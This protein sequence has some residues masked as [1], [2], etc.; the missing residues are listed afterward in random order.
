MTHR[1]NHILNKPLPRIFGIFVLIFSLGTIF[2]LSRN[3]VLFDTEAALGNTPKDVQVSNIQEDSLTVSFVTDGS[4][5]G[6][7]TYGKDI[8]L[9]EVAFD[10]RDIEGS[11]PHTVHYITLKNLTPNTKYLFSIVSGDGVFKKDESHFEATTASGPVAKN[12]NETLASGKVMLESGS[13]PTEAIAYL[14]SENPP[15]ELISTLVKPDGSYTLNLSSLRKSDLSDI[16]PLSENTTLELQIIDNVSKSTLSFLSSQANPIPPIA[17]SK[18]YNFVTGND[19][20]ASTTA[21]DS[22]QITGFPI[23]TDTQQVASTPVILTPKS[24]EELKD[25]QP[26]FEGKALPNSDVEIT[27]QSNHEIVTTVQSDE[28]GNWEFRPDTALEPGEHKITVKTL[29]A[30]G[31]LQTL[32]RSFTVFAQGSQFVEP[33]VSPT[34]APTVVPTAQPTLIPTATAAPTV[35]PTIAPT[36]APTPIVIA[37]TSVISPAITSPAPII[38]TPPIPASGSSALILGII[39][40]IL[41]IGIGGLIFLLI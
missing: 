21:S 15:S 4:V 20:I 16:I 9:G 23:S 3:V 12:S 40:T 33:S 27:I 37:P 38:T 5:V 24:G 14:K 22:A 2:W 11:M 41:T 31:V 34:I 28:T 25:Q 29:N 26:L 17:L 1:N 35:A 8:N 18:N 10:D 39:G 19:P 6:S 36:V 30:A 7:I 32:T 13:A